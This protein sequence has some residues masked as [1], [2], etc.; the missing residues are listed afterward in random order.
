MQDILDAL[1][2]V[3][4]EMQQLNTHLAKA[5]DLNHTMHKVAGTFDSLHTALAIQRSCMA[6]DMIFRAGPSGELV[7]SRPG[8][9]HTKLALCCRFTSHRRKRCTRS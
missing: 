7:A 8:K 9:I 6:E 4:A 3:A 5:K 2:D 1:H